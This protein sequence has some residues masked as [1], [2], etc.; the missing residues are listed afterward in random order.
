MMVYF[1]HFQKINAEQGRKQ[2][3]DWHDKFKFLSSCRQIAKSHQPS[4]VCERL[5]IK[6]L[7]LYFILGKLFQF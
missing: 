2:K 7:K 1:F 5:I 4:D 6:F 3:E